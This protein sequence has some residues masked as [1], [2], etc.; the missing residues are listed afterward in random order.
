MGC[1]PGRDTAK[2]LQHIAQEFII[3][4]ILELCSHASCKNGVPFH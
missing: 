2:N 4:P 1:G 3:F